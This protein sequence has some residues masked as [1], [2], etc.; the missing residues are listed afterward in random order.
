MDCGSLGS[1]LLKKG[2]WPGTFDAG[3]VAAVLIHALIPVTFHWSAPGV[4]SRKLSGQRPTCR[5]I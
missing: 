3:G 4:V 5:F 2:S 1:V